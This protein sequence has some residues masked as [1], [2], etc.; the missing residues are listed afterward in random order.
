VEKQRQ[1]REMQIAREIQQSL[2]PRGC[3]A[4]PGFEVAAESES[5]YQVGGDYYDFIPL[6]KGRLALA[7]ADVSGKGAPASILMASVHASLRALAGGTPPDVLAS[8]LNR[9]LYESTQPNKFVTLFYGELDPAARRLVYVNCG[10]IPPFHLGKDGPVDRLS[11]GG[12]ALG[13]LEDA[14]FESGSVDLRPSDV[15]AIVTDG[16]T[17]AMSP[18]GVELGDA[19]VLSVLRDAGDA[20]ATEVLRHLV[21]RVASWTGAA[22]CSDDLTA[23]I[24]K[25]L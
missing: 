21:A 3:P 23:L 14:A 8:R 25:A 16:A 11:L 24:L 20:R 13:L 18:E 22:G 4:V 15:V 6:P 12:P 9:F 17:E 10:H 19:R 2:F 1:D 7:V 5:C